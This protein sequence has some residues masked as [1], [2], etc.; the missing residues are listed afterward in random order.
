MN[1]RTVARRAL[2]GRLFAL[3][4]ELPQQVNFALGIKGVRWAV[5]AT[6]LGLGCCVGAFL[7]VA[8]SLGHSEVEYRRAHA[9]EALDLDNSYRHWLGSVA[10]WSS[11]DGHAA[12][13]LA[14]A[15][16]SWARF[17]NLFDA[18]CASLDRQETGTELSVLCRTYGQ[19]R[20]VPLKA[21]V[22]GAI[23]DQR[24]LA[25][26]ELRDLL[27]L[28]DRINGIGID[29]SRA[30]NGLVGHALDE[31]E[32]ALTVLFVSTCGFLGGGLVL[33][34]LIGQ[35]SIRHHAQ[36][37]AAE[38]A[39][40]AAEKSAHILQETLE[41]LPAGVVLYDEHDRLML[42]NAM[43]AS[44]T[45]ILNDPE[46]IGK[47]YA[48]LA[49]AP[50]AYRADGSLPDATERPDKLV[51]NSNSRYERRLR[52]VKGDRWFEWSERRT[53]SGRTVSL[54]TD[55]T[56]LKSQELEIERM[57]E[58]YLS[59]VGALSDVVFRM[60]LDSGKLSF[61]SPAAQDLFQVPLSTLT[62]RRLLDFVAPSDVEKV[63]QLGPQ[64][65][66]ASDQVVHQVQFRILMRS[67][68][69]KHVEARFRRMPGEERPVIAGVLRDVE[70]QIW[71][72][73][74]L[75]A[76][77]NHLRSIVESSGALVLLTNRDLAVVMVNSG[78]VDMT[79]IPRETA[80]G[81]PLSEIVTWPLDAGL[82]EN[83]RGGRWNEDDLLTAQLTCRHSDADGRER[84]LNITAK[85]VLGETGE[86]EQFVFV[87]VDDTER[88]DAEQALFAT[89][90]LAAVGEMSAAVAH[91]IAQP[92]QVINLACHSALDELGE[93]NGSKTV[94]LAYIRQKLERI[95][96]QIE[97]SNRIVGD[98][99]AFVRGAAAD[100]ARPFD[101]ADAV[102]SAV[103]LTSH[104]LQQA[105]VKLTVSLDDSHRKVAGHIGKLEQVLVNLINN[106][107]DAGGS[108]VEVFVRSETQDGGCEKV[109]VT[110]Q[111]NGPGI[112]PDVLRRL[113]DAFITTKPRGQGTG[114]GLRV[115]RR[116]VEEMRG[117]ISGSNRAEGGARFDVVLPAIS[118]QAS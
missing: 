87:G 93:Q 32:R 74:R 79:G 68:G 84:I 47:T 5:V 92:L 85:P 25:P 59:L 72:A 29:S 95:A 71:L 49:D 107:R 76:E 52:R 62:E 42:F 118:E 55:V 53:P 46:A 3:L 35:A 19:G 1:L 8:I 43:A 106:A 99:R 6:V 26:E 67:G 50:L 38:K 104:G 98:L 64:A 81:R 102:R 9:V 45:P 75:E 66:A 14:S 4:D 24:R 91:E 10:F 94:D 39:A 73:E 44:I 51:E 37:I 12:D 17:E 88:R 108:H 11:S 116:I 115:C 86:A 101:P 27:V 109:R 2:G 111:D 23:R 22:E 105:K 114:L 58:E 41:A 80:I 60:D 103:D 83:W 54:R 117:T 15:R 56:A 110:V 33:M 113:F 70:A 89:E 28:R 18:T 97:R 34:F 7:D 65:Q 77:R 61:V 90:R 112:R 30:I 36:K 21:A 96:S 69:E 57:H 20:L 82:F 78:F 63:R 40:S 100:E 48:E 13:A 31:R 16:E